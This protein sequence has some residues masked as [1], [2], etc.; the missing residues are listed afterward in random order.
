MSDDQTP[1]VKLGLDK[2]IDSALSELNGF[3]C[4]APEFAK[5]VEQLDK[6]YK[7]RAYEPEKVIVDNRTVKLETL[8]P[9][10]GNLVG[11]V[12]ILGYEH[13]HVVTSKALGFVI[14][15]RV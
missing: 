2:A 4:D 1:N 5:I 14:K 7:M 12:A 9:I 15:S 11:I 3:T 8:L 10:I 6:F 13:A